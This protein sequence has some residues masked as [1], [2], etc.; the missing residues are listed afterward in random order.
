[1]FRSGDK[2]HGLIS[3]LGKWSYGRIQFASRVGVM[4]TPRDQG[5]EEPPTSD[6]ESSKCRIRSLGT[7]PTFVASAFKHATLYRQ[8]RESNRFAKLLAERT[9]DRTSEKIALSGAGFASK[10]QETI[11]GPSIRRLASE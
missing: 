11:D 8:K 1:M 3:R 4:G 6:S 10:L 9:R 7:N 2:P 5:G